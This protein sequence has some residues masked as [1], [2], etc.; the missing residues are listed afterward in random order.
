MNGTPLTSLTATNSAINLVTTEINDELATTRTTIESVGE[1]IEASLLAVQNEVS[2][3]A[4]ATRNTI[5]SVGE[6]LELS[7]AGV[8]TELQK[9]NFTTDGKLIVDEPPYISTS[10]SSVATLGSGAVFTGTAEQVN[11]YGI[12]Y[13]SVYAN[14]ASASNG[15]A[16]QQSIDGTN[17]DHSDEFTVPANKGKNFSINP[18]AKYYRVVYTNGGTSQATFRLQTILKVTGKP[19]SHRIQDS[20]ADDDD[21]EL[22]KAVMTGKNPAGTFVNFAATTAGNFKVSIEEFENAVSVNSNSQ[23]RVTPYH[24]DGS[25]GALLT[26]T[27]YVSGK[28]GIDASTETLNTIGYEHHE[29]HAGSHFMLC[30]YV[31]LSINQVYDIQ[32]TTPNT[33]KESHL[34]FGIEVESETL[35][36]LFEGVTIATA[37]SA[38]GVRNNNRNSATVTGMTVNGILNSSTANADADTVISA[39]TIMEQSIVGVGKGSL[40]SVTRENEIVLKKNAIYSLR[41]TAT[42]AGYINYCLHWYEH[43]PKN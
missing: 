21:A 43:T 25:A 30:D 8:T 34:V 20:I 2:D 32:I 42:A 18:H 4:L 23:L 22:V 33:T 1:E 19:S 9:L 11:G 28:S 12:I 29:I 14:V 36:Q 35:L 41:F 24:A 40:G 26:G 39:A 17:W 37:G 27:D 7:V 10:N 15:L 16:I 31:D 13:V 5:E 3:E 38:L 6:E